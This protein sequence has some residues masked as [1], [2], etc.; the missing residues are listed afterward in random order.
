MKYRIAVE[1]AATAALVSALLLPLLASAEPFVDTGNQAKTYLLQLMTPIASIGVLLVGV[2]CLTGRIAW[3]FLG[4][5]LVG[6]LIIFGHEQIITMVR[7][8]GGV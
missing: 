1:R 2:L 3:G 7:G 8:W 6:V 5:A 4:A